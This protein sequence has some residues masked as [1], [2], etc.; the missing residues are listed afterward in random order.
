MDT[1]LYIKNMVCDRCIMAVKQKLNDENLPP[2]RVEM[3][4]GHITDVVSGGRKERL[5]KALGNLG[6]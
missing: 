3:G 2:M 6:V 1:V 4:E 5:R